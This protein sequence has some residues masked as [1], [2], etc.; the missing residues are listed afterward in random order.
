[1]FAL[2]P[3]IG[4][5][6]C[7]MMAHAIGEFGQRKAT[8]PLFA[9]TFNG[10]L[11]AAS[12]TIVNAPGQKLFASLKKLGGNR[13]PARCLRNG[14]HQNRKRAVF[15]PSLH[16]I[17]LFHRGKIKRIGRQTV[18]RVRGHTNHLAALDV[19]GGVLNG[20]AVWGSR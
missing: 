7:S 8:R 16:P 4:P 10:K 3:V 2:V 5:P 6:S 18:K 9:V 12:T 13:G 17:D 19:I 11:C 15:R 14:V 20:G 1:M